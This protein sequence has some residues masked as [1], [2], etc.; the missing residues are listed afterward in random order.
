M[1]L[2]KHSSW[3]KINGILE[4]ILLIVFIIWSL[5][6]GVYAFLLDMY[7]YTTNGW[8]LNAD[9]F[10]AIIRDMP[11]LAKGPKED[12]SIGTKRLCLGL[13]LSTT[14]IGAI[15]YFIKAYISDCC[16][17]S[18]EFSRQYSW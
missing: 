11:S 8:N 6:Y 17:I 7:F 12:L 16:D 3:I 1:Q 18:F 9:N 2:I 14:C 10:S 4:I 5:Y 13:A 15:N